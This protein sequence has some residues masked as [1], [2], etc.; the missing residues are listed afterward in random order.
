[1]SETWRD[2]VENV[3]L[4]RFDMV[5]KDRNERV[6]DGVVI[7][8]N[9]KL[10]YSLQDGLYDGVGKIEVYPMN[11]FPVVKETE[12]NL[13]LIGSIKYIC[14]TF[15]NVGVLSTWSLEAGL[16]YIRCQTCIESLWSWGANSPLPD[17]KIVFRRTLKSY[18]IK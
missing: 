10:K 2:E 1:M 8:I 9:D 15:I 16:R 14:I 6:G 12:E 3:S 7:F 5:R 17:S 13:I 4:K 11:F 18:H